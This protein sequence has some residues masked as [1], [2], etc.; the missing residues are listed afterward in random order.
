MNTL[1][2]NYGFEQLAD[3]TWGISRSFA[4]PD[5][6]QVDVNVSFRQ[7]E[8]GNWVY[9]DPT[10]QLHYMTEDLRDVVA[11]A[12]TLIASSVFQLTGVPVEEGFDFEGTWYTAPFMFGDYF[13]WEVEVKDGQ[14]WVSQPADEYGVSYVSWR[15][16]FAERII[17]GLAKAP[18]NQDVTR[19]PSV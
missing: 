5:G 9:V 18:D 17:S 10:E 14:M 15:D 13:D 4:D 11:F 2:T 19:S 12:Q 7:N 8:S 3:G 16:D 1:L 6:S